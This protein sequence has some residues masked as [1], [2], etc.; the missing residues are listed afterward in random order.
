[1]LCQI[2]VGNCAPLA[3]DIDLTLQCVS[4]QILLSH[5][6]VGDVLCKSLIFVKKSLIEIVNRTKFH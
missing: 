5:E 2:L 6:N 1:M 3:T 4:L